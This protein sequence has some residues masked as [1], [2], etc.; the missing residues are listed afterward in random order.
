M[1]VVSK[2]KYTKFDKLLANFIIIIFSITIGL[3]ILS[4]LY[5][6]YFYIMILPIN[7]VSLKKMG[8]FVIKDTF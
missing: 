4:G 2:M 7:E 8:V 1:I 3:I 6:I 5:D